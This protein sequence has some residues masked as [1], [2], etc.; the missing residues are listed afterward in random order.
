MIANAHTRTLPTSMEMYFTDGL[1]CT[2]L[3]KRHKDFKNDRI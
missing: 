2:L 3:E 1:L